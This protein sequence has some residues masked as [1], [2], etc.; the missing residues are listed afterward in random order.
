MLLNKILH[1][2]P[3]CDP[4]A[5]N[6]LYDRDEF[7][8][9]VLTKGSQFQEMQPWVVIWLAMHV[10]D[11]TELF[12]KEKDPLSIFNRFDWIARGGYV[13]DLE[14]Y[15]D[16]DQDDAIYFLADLQDIAEVQFPNLA[17]EP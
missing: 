11:M 9:T 10:E 8:N 1:D 2:T 17:S 4:Q 12:G 14:D 7:S 16:L 13:A 6:K 5:L 3:G 15:N